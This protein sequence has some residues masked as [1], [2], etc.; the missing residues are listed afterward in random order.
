MSATFSSCIS[1]N[2][3]NSLHGL[4]ALSEIKGT[5]ED[6]RRHSHFSTLA[7]PQD[8]P[9]V[10][11][12]VGSDI[13]GNQYYE[14]RQDVANRD[15]WVIFQKWDY[16]AT[17]VPPQWH[18]WLH[19]VTDCHPDTI[20]DNNLTPA[21]FENMTGTKGKYAL[22]AFINLYRLMLTLGAY[23]PYSTVRPRISSWIGKPISRK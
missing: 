9:K 6:I 17:Q 5:E 22:F 18:Q 23:R 15:R 12:L 19:K 10:G 3:N 21:H 20:K 8:Q 7:L 13:H 2:T 4:L 16:D 14:N 1:V 11:R